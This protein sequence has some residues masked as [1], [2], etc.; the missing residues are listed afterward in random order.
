[1]RAYRNLR[2]VEYPDI[3][4]IKTDRNKERKFEKCAGL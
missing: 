1:M 2:F 3:A 4:D